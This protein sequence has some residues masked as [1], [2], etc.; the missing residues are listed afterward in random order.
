MMA[1]NEVEV[2][3]VVVVVFDK[4]DDAVGNICD[5]ILCTRRFASI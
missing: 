5:A 3:V 4:M 1:V 2:R